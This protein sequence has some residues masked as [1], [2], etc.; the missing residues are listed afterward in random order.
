MR[1]YFL[2]FVLLLA[3]KTASAFQF[4][5]GTH[6]NPAPDTKYIFYWGEYQCDLTQTNGYK[7]QL[8]LTASRFR[9][10]L[11]FP[12]K[13]WNGSALLRDFTFKVEGLS[14]STADYTSRV[15][16]LDAALSAKASVGTVFHVSNLPLGN[17]VAGSV[18][19]LIRDP[20]DKKEFIPTRGNWASQAP[21]L[22]EYFL[23]RVSW[24]RED[25]SKI[26]DR[27]FFTVSEFWQ[28]VR[29]QP[30]AEW[31][32]DATPQTIRALVNFQ[33]PESGTFGLSALL[34][35]DNEY[36]EMLNNL[37]NYKHLARPG[38]IISLELQAAKNY[39]RLYKKQLILVA[40]NDPRLLLRRSRDTHT[41]KIEWGAFKETLDGL[42]MRNFTKSEGETVAMDGPIARVAM[43]SYSDA[44]KIAMIASPLLCLID[45]ESR[46]ALS[47]RLTV[48]DEAYNM[49]AGTPF[50]DSLA[51]KIAAKCDE[52]TALKLDSF[53]LAGVELP[54]L[55][56]LIYFYSFQNSVLV[57]NE[58]DMLQKSASESSPAELFPPVVTDQ[59]VQ[60]SFTLPK[61]ASVKLS[62]FESNGTLVQLTDG[63]YGAG[64]QQV[65][66]PRH[67]IKPGVK[68]FVFLN[69]PFGVVKEE[70]EGK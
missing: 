11:L 23:E 68:Y 60:I 48:A 38:A 33:G 51:A 35:D 20:E 22:N 61:E 59:D 46:S 42:Y 16:E 47:F 15:G 29:L 32:P 58:F 50:P 63:K 2:F 67:L 21:F 65:S 43:L 49:T 53:T 19:I 30:Y 1:P 62:L 69:T 6:G 37:N 18:D 28:T 44:N 36:R 34:S 64:R 27:D 55:S 52:K 56:F 39:E 9:E 24:G 17:G 14:V 3:A 57:G 31:Q 54:P 26:S 12:P 40:D 7:C 10:V 4:A 8:A 13:I 70:M 41:L 25:I 5:D 45:G 66:I